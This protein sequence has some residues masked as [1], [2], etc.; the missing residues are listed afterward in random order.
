MVRSSLLCLLLSRVCALNSLQPV[1]TDDASAVVVVPIQK[2]Y[3]PVVQDNKTVAYKTS[4]FGSL[5]IGAPESQPFTVVFDTGSGHLILP[6]A[7]CRSETCT[8]HNR[9]HRSMSKQAVDIEYTGV[10]LAADAK[11]RDQVSISFGTGEVLGE[12]V[13]DV[14][15][16]GPESNHTEEVAEN[17]ISP[18]LTLRTVL[19]TKMSEDPFGL[20]QFDGVMGLGLSTLSLTPEFN[21]LGQLAAQNP[22]MQPRFGFFLS[23]HDEG[24]SFISFGGP[25]ERNAAS[26]FEW[27]STAKGDLGYWQVQVKRL[28]IGDE[29]L[30]D[31]D[32]GSCHAILDTGSSMVGVPRGSVRAMQRYLAR[33]VP[34]DA[35]EAE[36]TGGPAV[37][38]RRIPGKSIHFDLGNDVVITIGPEDIGRPA[39]IE[40]TLPNAEKTKQPF[41]RSL[42]LPL[43]M[44]APIGP[45]VFIFGEPLLRRWYTQYDFVE[46]KVGFAVANHE[47]DVAN[48]DGKALAAVGAPTT[49]SLVSGAPLRV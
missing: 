9:Y 31:C 6:S 35:L 47:K 32:D 19:A 3:V 20:F 30:E 15:C 14:V 17:A 41:C 25:I 21:F 48:E 49:D 24:K 13:Q 27:V 11:E 22:N 23:A 26:D 38:C 2:Q 45:K 39:P 40:I 12:F 33:P 42:L 36:K 44:A 4:Y 29:V 8:K 7:A 28:R 16:V 18:C 43:D 37:D 10:P 5:R 1:S 46:G 34:T